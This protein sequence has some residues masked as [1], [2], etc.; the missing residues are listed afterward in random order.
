M[1]GGGGTGRGCSVVCVIPYILSS[2]TSFEL[3]QHSQFCVGS[4]EDTEKFCVGSHEGIENITLG[5]WNL[6]LLLLKVTMIEKKIKTHFWK[7]K[8][9][10]CVGSHE[11]IE[12]ITLGGWNLI[13]LLKVTKMEKKTLEKQ[14]PLL[15]W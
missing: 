3:M 5:G 14:N 8:T 7:N 15:R 10:F 9:Q 6:V 4:H 12:N 2:R 13:L 1:G 11:N